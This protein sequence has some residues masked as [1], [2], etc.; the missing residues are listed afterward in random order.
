MN[1]QA[2]SIGFL[3]ISAEN[4]LFLNN[5]RN[6][7]LCKSLDEHTSVKSLVAEYDGKLWSMQVL[8]IL[9]LTPEASAV[10]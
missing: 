5:P 1:A 8:R 3:L 9:G 2:K 4:W 10:S 7:T 6:S